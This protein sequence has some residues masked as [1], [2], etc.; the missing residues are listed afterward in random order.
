GPKKPA[1]MPELISCV[2]Q[3][4]TDA[5]PL[6][7]ANVELFAVPLNPADRWMY[8]G[9]TDQEGKATIKTMGDFAGV[10]SGKY[11]VVVSKVNVETTQLDKGRVHNKTISMIDKKYSAKETTTLTIEVQNQ[12][13]EQTFDLGKYQEVLL[14]EYTI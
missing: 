11:T 2:L 12:P 9:V 14:E 6:A 4:N 8:K 7:D 1:N 5:G 3:F 13:I 10:P